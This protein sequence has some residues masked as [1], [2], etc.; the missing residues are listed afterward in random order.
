[1][2]ASV[3]QRPLW[4]AVFAVALAWS[5]LVQVLGAFAYSPWGWNM[6]AVDAEGRANVDLPQ[7]QHRLWS[8]RD[9]QIGYLIA[10]F[11]AARAERFQ[12]VEY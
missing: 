9:W 12:A 1:V 8:F 3:L 11:A 7:Y 6:K 2:L 5:V 4:R 10:N